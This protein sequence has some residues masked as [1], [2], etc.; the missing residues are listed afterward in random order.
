MRLAGFVTE[1]LP[2]KT[3]HGKA[4]TVRFR[5]VAAQATLTPGVTRTLQLGLSPSLLHALERH[6][7]ESGAFTLTSASAGGTTQVGAQHRLRL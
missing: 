3:K 5:L 7:R 6:I 4:R 2:A 1:R